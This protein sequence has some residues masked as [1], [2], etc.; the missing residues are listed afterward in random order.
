MTQASAPKT[1]ELEKLAYNIDEAAAILGLS[2][3][4]VRNLLASGRLGY[5]TAANR[6]LIS[7]AAMDRFLASSPEREVRGS[8]RASQ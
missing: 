6:V 2:A 5:T 1:T 7:R 3:G 4:T 8:R